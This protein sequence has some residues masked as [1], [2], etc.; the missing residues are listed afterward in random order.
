M[1]L[2]NSVLTVPENKRYLKTHL[3]YVNDNHFRLIACCLGVGLVWFGWG[4]FWRVGVVFG[5]SFRHTVTLA[6]VHIYISII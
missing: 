4:F 1:L 3:R 6:E 5:F 2:F